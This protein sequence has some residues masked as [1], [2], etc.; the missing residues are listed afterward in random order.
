MQF[1][2]QRLVIH[3]DIK[4]RNI[5]VTADGT[6]K[7][8]DFGI[9]K[10]L[11]P[12]ARRKRRRGRTARVH[13]RRR[14]P[15]ADPRRADDRDERRLRPRRS[16]LPVD[17]GAAAVWSGAAPDADLIRAICEDAPVRPRTAALE[18]TH[19][20]VSVELEWVVLKA[21]RKEP[22][23]RYG[24]V[25]QLAE[26][27]RRFLSGRPVARGARFATVSRAQVRRSDTARSSP[28]ACC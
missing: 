15:G 25:E 19:F 3:R 5:L 7:L 12:G 2:H 20:D 11:E 23:R 28:P 17:R 1:A 6:P 27:I 4:P 21:L 14:E 10:L 22:D 16:A 9:A 26:D 18:G 13:A 8:L 24:S